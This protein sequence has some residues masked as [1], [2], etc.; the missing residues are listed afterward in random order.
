MH[1]EEKN[2]LKLKSHT[3]SSSRAP[4]K[5]EGFFAEMFRFALIA[6]FIILPIRLFIAEPFIVSGTSMF[7]SF[8]TGE[9]IIV[10]QLTYRFEQPERGDVIIF[11]YPKDTSRDFIKRI[12]GLPGETVVVNTD[13][14][15]IKNSEHPDGFKLEE[16]YVVDSQGLTLETKLATDEYFVMGDNRPVSSDSRIW[17]PLNKKYIIG[18]ALVRLFPPQKIN[19]FP[20][21]YN[22]PN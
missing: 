13:S 15:I 3:T 22:A 12:I 19:I 21:K 7:P 5:E 16:P 6:L 14:I 11:K 17:G 9:Y 4:E 20:E 1:E 8:N 18:R 10:D 2:D